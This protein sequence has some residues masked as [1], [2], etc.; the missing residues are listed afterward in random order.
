MKI[1]E[2]FEINYKGVGFTLANN[3]SLKIFKINSNLKN[4]TVKMF[5]IINNTI[6]TV[7]ITFRYLNSEV[8]GNTFSDIFI[9]EEKENWKILYL[10]NLVILL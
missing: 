2:G 5:T 3:D 10:L 6:N 7:P 8:K 4:L 9:N 1:N